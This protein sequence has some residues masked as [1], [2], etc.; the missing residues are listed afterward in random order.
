M[1]SQLALYLTYGRQVDLNILPC[2]SDKDLLSQQRLNPPPDGWCI[3]CIGV[4][5][6]PLV[7]YELKDQ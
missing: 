1:H 4:H 3:H 2:D 5:S 7:Q 6:L